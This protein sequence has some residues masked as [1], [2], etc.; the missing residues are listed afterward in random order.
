MK[1][2][3]LISN[4]VQRFNMKTHLKIL[5]ILIFSL[6]FN[7]NLS[8]DIPHFV[9]FKYILNQSDAGKK[10]QTFLKE[11][12]NSGIKKLQNQEKTIQEEEK[13]IIQ[14]KKIISNEEYKKK[15][16]ELRKKVASLQKERQKLL[17]SVAK[18]RAKAK[19]EILKNLNPI[20]KEY[21]KEKKIRMVVDK[22]GILLADENLDLTKEITTLLNKK[23][24]S[25]KLN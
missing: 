5:T 23:L 21:M 17:D 8:A 6:F 13:K 2:K 4:L 7:S 15:V 1:Q 18:Q 22:K 9:D 20:I 19:Q 12:L 24:K 10:A 3:A 11:K 14:Q 25:I 16:T